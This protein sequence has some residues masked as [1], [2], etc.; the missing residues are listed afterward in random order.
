MK[1]KNFLHAI[2]CSIDGL[3]VL[4]K[5]KAVKREL[6]LILFSICFIIFV[7]PDIVIILLLLVLPL[8]ILSIE[9]INTAIEYICNEITTEISDKIK[10]I[11][12]LGSVAVFFSL[13]AYALV[14]IFSFF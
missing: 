2:L 4:L 14:I 10:K 11:K 7:K 1:N 13:L 9:A 8:I 6:L 5:E 3:N 12:D